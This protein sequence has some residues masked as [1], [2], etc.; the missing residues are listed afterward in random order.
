MKKDANAAVAALIEANARVDASDLNGQ[1][2]LFFA[3]AA[4]QCL[5]ITAVLEARA[6]ANVVDHSGRCALF[7]AVRASRV[8]VASMLLAQCDLPGIG[9]ASRAR[10]KGIMEY[11]AE[12]ARERGHPE[13]VEQLKTGF[14]PLGSDLPEGPEAGVS[15][16]GGKKEP[17]DAASVVATV[18]KTKPAPARC[19]A[20]A[21]V[22]EDVA[23]E[24]KARYRVEF[25]DPTDP[26]GVTMIALHTPAYDERL[27]WL[28]KQCPWLNLDLLVPK[29]PANSRL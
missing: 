12:M 9:V 5:A 27:R 24:K 18:K 3:A 29:S 15:I 23:V 20:K 4:G 28:Q 14:P 7:Y 1:T 21:R 19:A 2:P 22:L 6:C 13:L 11:M 10:N 25:D 17:E 16:L 26:T 8:E